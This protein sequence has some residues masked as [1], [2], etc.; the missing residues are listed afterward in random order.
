MTR[1][2]EVSPFSAEPLPG[3][4]AAPVSSAAALREQGATEAQVEAAQSP[5]AVSAADWHGC[6]AG[7]A[8]NRWYCFYEDS[9]WGGRRLQWIDPH[10]NNGPSYFGDYGFRDKASG[11]SNTTQNPGLTRHGVAAA[12]GRRHTRVYGACCATR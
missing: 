2:S 1:L 4:N 10:C 5:S 3:Q 8:D 12:G 7:Q 6:P 11:W 9:N